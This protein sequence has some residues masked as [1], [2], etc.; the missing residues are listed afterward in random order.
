MASPDGCSH[1]TLSRF[2]A[3]HF[4]VIESYPVMKATVSFSFLVSSLT[5]QKLV[6]NYAGIVQFFAIVLKVNLRNNLCDVPIF[7]SMQS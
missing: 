2:P 7:G 6:L 1:Q 5:G 4:H 3:A